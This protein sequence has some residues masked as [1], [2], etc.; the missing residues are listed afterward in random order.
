MGDIAKIGECVE[1][2]EEERIGTGD[3]GVAMFIMS[4]AQGFYTARRRVS[5]SWRSRLLI[6]KLLSGDLLEN[7][8]N[9]TNRGTSQK[10]I[11][12]V[13][14][15]GVLECLIHR[16]SRPIVL[17][18]DWPNSSHQQTVQKRPPRSNFG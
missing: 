5:I 14:L 7:K 18:F 15:L 8:R 13:L 16:N 10:G 6:A 11:N 17:F 9:Q 2:G 12:L 3:C 1:G 4:A